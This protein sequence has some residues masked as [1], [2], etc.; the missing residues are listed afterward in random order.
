MILDRV[1]RKS[2][3]NEVKR[4]E[5]Q[6]VQGQPGDRNV[7]SKSCVTSALITQ[8]LETT[9][10]VYPAT[11]IHDNRTDYRWPITRWLGRFNCLRRQKF[12]KSRCMRQSC[13]FT[14]TPQERISRI[15]EIGRVSIH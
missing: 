1:V 8:G 12:V 9:F 13:T 10:S 7:T 15:A 4:I 2:L 6:K 11:T 14:D 5:A 3:F